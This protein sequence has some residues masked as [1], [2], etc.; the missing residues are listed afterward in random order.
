MAAPGPDGAS[1]PPEAKVL[2]V[3][4]ETLRGE[5][6]R[7]LAIQDST[8]PLFPWLSPTGTTTQD[9]SVLFLRSK[10][11]A[12]WRQV[13]A[14]DRSIK[15]TAVAYRRSIDA[16]G[17]A[18]AVLEQ[19]Q[20]LPHEKT[21]PKSLRWVAFEC[22]RWKREATALREQLD[23]MPGS[24]HNPHLARVQ[25]R[26]ESTRRS[27]NMARRSARV[28]VSR[29]RME[30]A[31]STENLRVLSRTAD[32]KSR[33]L[34]QA[35]EEIAALQG[36]LDEQS[37][38]FH[39]ESIERTRLF[40]SQRTSSLSLDQSV[41]MHSVL[42]RLTAP[43]V[44]DSHEY[45]A[46]LRD[47]RSIEQR[48][49]RVTSAATA[50]AAA[51]GRDARKQF[52]STIKRTPKMGR[53]RSVARSTVQVETLAGEWDETPKSRSRSAIAASRRALASNV[54]AATTETPTR[55]LPPPVSVVRDV[56][57]PVVVQ[58]RV[59]TPV[60][61]LA[62]PFPAKPPEDHSG[63]LRAAMDQWKLFWHRSQT[64]RIKDTVETLEVSNQRLRASLD[65]VTSKADEA[66]QTMQQYVQEFSA[67]NRERRLA[68]CRQNARV[69]TVLVSS[70]ERLATPWELDMGRVYKV[71]TEANHKIAHYSSMVEAYKVRL[72]RAEAN[73]KAALAE[74]E[75]QKS[76]AESWRSATLQAVKAYSSGGSTSPGRQSQSSADQVV[77]T[78][79]LLPGRV[80]PLAGP[81][82]LRLP[83]EQLT[84]PKSLGE[85]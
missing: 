3:S 37:K 53:S 74:C 83:S 15:A 1:T 64:A 52:E 68:R 62:F 21:P 38:Q 32:S 22:E 34:S 77:A 75:R 11:E 19:Q 7:F 42:P 27:A 13:H 9:D 25:E 65:Q 44:E 46:L 55:P 2:R 48:L 26:L 61:P 36:A 30:L 76:L 29:L 35:R 31:H 24:E 82:I 40:S 78:A 10:G 47:Y 70:S 57:P 28:Q 6:A 71:A 39:V 79:P 73:W 18:L 56:P 84:R 81:G 85:L 67:K 50:V 43:R 41:T 72:D 49:S 4:L 60:R 80:A 16:L 45:Q 66:I 5:A 51:V 59:Q 8:G 23:S 14:V 63:A 58:R 54:P 17:M 20:L 69:G 12:R 33:L